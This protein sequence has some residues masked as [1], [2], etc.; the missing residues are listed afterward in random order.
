MCWLMLV[1]VMLVGYM[2]VHVPHRLVA[3]QVAV[4]SSGHRL[5]AVQ[6]VPV[7]VSLS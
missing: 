1:R 7:V 2:R 3:V 5:V 4:H 6:V